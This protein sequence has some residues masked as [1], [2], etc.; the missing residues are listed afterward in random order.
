MNKLLIQ[1]QYQCK[2]IRIFCLIIVVF[3]LLIAGC[4]G[5]GKPPY[6]VEKYLLNYP[7][8]SRGSLG[9]L[10][11]SIKFNRF[12]IATAYNSVNM[13]FSDDPY[14]FDSF[15][16]SRWAVNPADMIADGLL[17]DFRESG[18]FQAIFSRYES[19]EGR[20]VISG[21]V[22]EFFMRI[23]KGD[24]KA[25]VSMVVSLK[26]TRQQEADKRI[27]FQKKYVREEPLQ[28]SSPKG[29]C[30]A[31]SQSMRIISEQIANDVY[32]VIKTNIQ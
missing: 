20:F 22:E 10:D 2:G 32:A 12:S 21:S 24:K 11:T 4:A 17:R 31:A 8:S 16:Y 6:A 30:Q 29:Y 3:S 13:I 5:S 1:K 28:E 9:K 18:L 25:V 15:N 27:I 14:S 23:E 7:A 26:D 19:D